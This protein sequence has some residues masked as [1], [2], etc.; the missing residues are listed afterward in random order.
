[1]SVTAAVGG[2]EESGAVRRRRLVLTVSTM[3]S[4]LLYTIDTTVANVALPVLQGNLSATREQAAWVMT[5]Y[6]I[7]SAAALP[8]LA[9]VDSRLGLR[10]AYVAAVVGFGIASMLCGLAPNIEALVAARFVQGLCGTALLPLAQTALQGVYPREQLGRVF[11]L[12]GVGV[13]AGP[14]LG[15]WVGGWLTDNFGWRSVFYIN[16]PFL[17]LALFGLLATLRGA[18]EPTPRVFDRL[19]YAL[20]TL[21]IVSL[22]LA[23]DRGEQLGWLDSREIV[24]ELSIGL[25]AGYMFFAHQ[26]TTTHTLYDPAITR[27]RNLMLGAAMSVFVGWSFMGAMVLLPQF[28]QEVQGY[29]V[30]SAGVL[31]A[32]RGIG[33][34]AAMLAL[35]RFATL[36]DPRKAFT[37]GAV[38]NSVGLMAFAG[39]PADAPATWLTGWLLLQ[40]VGLGL[41][42]VPLNALGFATLP[43][44][45]RTAGG[46][47]MTLGRNLGGSIGV[48]L[49][50][51]GISQDAHANG[52]RLLEIARPMALGGPTG[53][54]AAG[55]GWLI[56]EVHRESLVIAYA[57]QHAWLAVLPLLMI[58]M[59]WAARRPDFSGTSAS[60]GDQGAPGAA[61]H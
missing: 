55:L 56:G 52:Q 14:I 51:R 4:T 21:C 30:V 32:P 2:T 7:A 38:I 23:L 6:L 43:A 39:A 36:I 49:L 28:L 20:L 1:M 11:A 47:L 19:G 25:L 60:N 15:P 10:R 3:L 18:P 48:A 57:N 45:L 44:H 8:A 12:L 27:D 41:I 61:P 54:D 53:M 33:L 13:M 31:V 40:G 58:P 26:S 29:S 9:A 35:S 16:V 24:L 17:A 59:V 50:I 42:F 22:Q 5:S 34:M 37:A 46:S